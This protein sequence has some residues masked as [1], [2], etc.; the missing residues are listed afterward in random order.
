MAFLEYTIVLICSL[1][2]AGKLPLHFRAWIYSFKKYFIKKKCVY[3]SPDAEAWRLNFRIRQPWRPSCLET[4]PENFFILQHG[5]C[6]DMYFSSLKC[7]LGSLDRLASVDIERL[8]GFTKNKEGKYWPPC[9]LENGF[10]SIP[11][12]HNRHDIKPKVECF[13]PYDV[14]WLFTLSI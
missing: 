9:Y 2:I 1:N 11:G 3:W 10:G 14:S 7:L 4:L 12:N 6:L 13:H 5:H 8:F